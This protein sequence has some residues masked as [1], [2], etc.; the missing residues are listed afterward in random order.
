MI[1]KFVADL[2]V[3]S[4]LS[5]CGEIEMTPRQIIMYAAALGIDIVAI[6]DHNASE[7]VKAALDAARNCG[8]TVIPGME[9][10]TREE[11]HVICL[12]P[13]FAALGDWQTVINQKLPN[14][15]NNETI[16]GAQFIVDA[17]D[18]LVAI[19]ERM[20]LASTDISVED[21]VVGVSKCGGICIAA[22]VDR[23]SYSV[24]SQLGFIPEGVNFAALEISRRITPREAYDRFP[25]TQSFPLITSSDAHRI[26]DLLSPKTIFYI[27]EPT[28]TEIVMAL[29]GESGRKVVVETPHIATL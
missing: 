14:L 11:I 7:N 20:L 10:Q 29:R 24:L 2:H 12:F 4:V 13:D 26:S 19:D 3:H 6:T 5:P 27:E 16:F 25:M 9:L 21:A 22:H 1:R 17:E 15:K 23:P 8:I 18:E 28:L